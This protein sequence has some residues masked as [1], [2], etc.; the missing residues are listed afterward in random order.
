MKICPKC[1]AEHV[2]PGIFCSRP[3][4]NSRTWS[5]ESNQIRSEKA[6]TRI[7]LL[8]SEQRKEMSKKAS[9]KAAELWDEKRQLTSTEDFGVVGRRRKVFEEQNNACLHCGLTEW[10]GEK[11]VL[12]LDHI[13]GDSSNNKRDNL[14]GLCPNCHSL[15]PTWR[16]KLRACRSTVGPSPD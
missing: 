8:S 4:A 9:D 5:D 11:I 12:E 13:N 1:N 6:K 10:M 3:C 7:A 16:G 15:T 14:R 2:K